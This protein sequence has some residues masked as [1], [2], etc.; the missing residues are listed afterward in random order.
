MKTILWIC[1]FFFSNHIAF[2]YA[3]DVSYYHNE[4]Y[5]FRIQ[6]P[7]GWQ[8]KEGV[9]KN[10]VKKA[11][12]KG[13]DVTI[14]VTDI[15]DIPLFIEDIRKDEDF[16]NL[17]DYEILKMAE[18]E[19]DSRKFSETEF[20][21]IMSDYVSSSI[22]EMQLR[23]H[24]LKVTEN[25]MT[26]LA[27]TKFI[28]IKYQHQMRIM[29]Q[30]IDFITLQFI[31]FR[32][33]KLYVVGGGSKAKDFQMVEPTILTSINSF[34]F[35]DWD[36]ALTIDSN[37]SLNNKTNEN[38]SILIF[39]LSGI[40]LLL[41][42]GFILRLVYNK[43]EIVEKETLKNENSSI[44][45]ITDIPKS[46]EVE[47]YQ[48]IDDSN[49]SDEEKARVYGDV[50]KLKGKITKEEITNAWKK[51]IEKYHPDKVSHLGEEFQNYAEKKSKDIN[52]AYAY[53]RRK[54]NF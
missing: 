47:T 12:Y 46:Y 37:A 50:L 14:N 35:E 4:K 5:K 2:L 40:S 13:S 28:Y 26:Y 27:N 6:F 43:K 19:F 7:A 51:M 38:N 32:R 8:I 3:Q 30:R 42:I 41:I 16:K 44:D 1:L 21:S 45:P 31:T 29:D 17:S 18:S 48:E 53:F 9:G 54:Y 20:E 52:K 25:R 39:I 10:I 23:F 11:V 33:G 15:R 49:L 22:N 34:Q 36:I 24:N